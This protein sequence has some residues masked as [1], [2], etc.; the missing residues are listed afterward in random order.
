MN[1]PVNSKSID[2]NNLLEQKL[3][4]LSFYQQNKFLLIH[5]SKKCIPSSTEETN[6]RI[7]KEC[8]SLSEEPTV[9]DWN[10]KRKQKTNN[11]PC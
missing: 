5:Y 1:T 4:L 10:Q 6:S 2:K 11:L 8:H 9:C 7:N 3:I